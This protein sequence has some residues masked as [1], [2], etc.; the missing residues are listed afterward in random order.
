MS[1]LLGQILGNVLGGQSQQVQQ[2]LPAILGQ[3]L[4]GQSAGGGGLQGL[5]AQLSQAGLGPQVQSW[6]GTGQNMPVN[7]EQLGQALPQEHVEQ[8]AQQT[9][10]SSAALLAVL[11]Q[12][13]PHAVDQATPEGQV[14]TTPTQVT[15][16][17]L[18]GKLFGQA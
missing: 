10:T 11:A 8:W 17:S 14:P 3:L 6:V 7:P 12:V 5:L 9:G 2:G 13:L 15:A 1:G 4:A 16:S 18:I